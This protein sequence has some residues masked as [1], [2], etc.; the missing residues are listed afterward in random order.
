LDLLPRTVRRAGDCLTGAGCPPGGSC[1]PA[2]LATSGWQ[3]RLD[4]HVGRLRPHLS[5][6]GAADAIDFYTRIR[7]TRR[8]PGH[9]W[10]I[11]VMRLD[12]LD[13]GH[14]MRARWSMSMVSWRSGVEMADVAKPLLYR[15]EFF[16]G[17]ML[18]LTAEVMRGPSLWTAGEREYMAVFTARLHRCSFCVETHTELTRIASDGE[19][20]AAN[21]DS[22]G[23]EVTAVVGLLETVTRTPDAVSAHDVDVVRDAGVPGEA[24]VDALHVNLV[25]N[26]VN[27]LA[28]T[29]DYRLRDGQIFKGVQSLHRFGYRFPGFLT[30]ARSRREHLAADAGRHAELVTNLRHA[31]FSS[32]AKTD[33]ATRAATVAGGSIPE[34]MW[35]Y[36][37]KVRDHADRLT[38]TDI[39]GLKVAGHNED[40]IYEIT[41]SATV[42]AAL[43]SLDAGLRRLWTTG[44]GDLR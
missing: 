16:G 11:T 34:P 20:D 38:D 26:I 3:D 14:R 42:G 28:H 6:T 33:T 44:G 27:R 7:R 22:V 24:I 17:A 19:I 2:G 12:V 18:D 4:R 29:F 41:V 30:G 35:S 43:G 8:R 40:E 23:R 25:W 31:V 39:E 32:P 1:G 37:A 10:V 15:P 13:R 9:Q 21:P 36:T 5:V